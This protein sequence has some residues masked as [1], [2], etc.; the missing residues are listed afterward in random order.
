MKRL[1]IALCVLVTYTAPQNDLYAQQ[2]TNM[3]ETNQSNLSQHGKR[4]HKKRKG[5]KRAK[6]AK[7]M[8]KDLTGTIESKSAR[9]YLIDSSG[10]KYSFSSDTLTKIR[11][12]RR[13]KV[14]ITCMVLMK[15][16]TRY[17]I[18]SISKIEEI[19]DD[20]SKGTSH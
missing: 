9:Y 14:Q 16:K 17:L 1:L 7:P 5:H 10:E 8:K 4:G 2:K 11:K 12:F 6:P 15:S 18:H 3:S 19:D 13:K 20:S